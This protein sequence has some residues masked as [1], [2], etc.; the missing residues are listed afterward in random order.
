TAGRTPARRAARERERAAAAAAHERAE[1]HE[2]YVRWEGEIRSHR[3]AAAAAAAESERL[4][5]QL[6]DLDARAAGLRREVEAVQD[7]IR[8]LDAAEGRHADALERAEAAVAAAEVALEAAVARLH[9]L[10]RER[11]S[12]AARA[13]A[14]RAVSTEAP[15]G[16]AA[17]LGSELDGVLGRL[18][19]HVRIRPGGE[20][21]VAAALGPLG[22]AVV[23]RSTLHAG[24]AV[25]HLRGSR[26]GRAVVLPARAGEAPAVADAPAGSR[27]V[28]DL[29]APN[30]PDPDGILAALQR[31]LAGTFVVGDWERAVALHQVH[32]ELTFVTT[33][34]DVAGPAAFAG[35]C[36]PQPSALLTAAAAENAERWVETLDAD[37]QRAA[38]EM[39][40]ARG[41]LTRRRDD[42]AAATRT[43]NESDALITGAAE[44]L[45]RLHRELE[46]N[47]RQR[48]L[49]QA[50]AEELTVA[51]ERHHRAVRELEAEEVPRSSDQEPAAD[52]TPQDALVEEELERAREAELAARIAVER[53][54]EQVV[55]LE[56]AVADLR[57]EAAEVERALAEA[58][59]RRELRRRHILRC[60]EL[61]T[62]AQQAAAVLERSVRDARAEH[63]RLDR[64]RAARE[65]DLAAARA[66]LRERAAELERV[67][68]ERHAADLRRAEIRHQLEQLERRLRAGFGLP[69][70][71]AVAQ[72]PDAANAS[73]D[74]LVAAEQA[75][76]REVEV[77]GRINP[78]AL[79]QFRA[80]EDRHRFL[81]GQVDDLL[82]SRHD[83]DEVIRAVDD[84]IREVFHGAFVDVAREFAT[85][86][87]ELFPGGDGRLLL[88]DPD[89]L[90][91]T[92]IEVEVRPPGKRVKRLSLLSGGE[93]SLTALGLLFAI[94]RARPSPFYV[95]DEVDAALDDVN[96]QRL[97]RL[98]ESFKTTSQLLVVT[99]Q[100]RTMEIAD[101]L[102]GVTMGADAVS[103]VVAERLREP[104]APG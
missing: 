60:G 101:L 55:Q 35:G 30:G 28:G 32:A 45:A 63:D 58:D 40:R 48:D 85:V 93:R 43:I 34:G 88:T 33:D 92:G 18:A 61:A 77:L 100:K 99:H 2:R 10:E 51:V 26:S 1:A 89:D 102:I 90:L 53:L 103:K 5:A 49:I 12:H 15:D 65:A 83:L 66:R 37:I 73:R 94:F 3:Q 70:D 36:D 54:D 71:D 14:L 74:D 13:Q 16:A 76:V 9:E 50:H 87:Q 56:R 57:R 19:D 39:H 67:R 38:G 46:S 31:A 59:R 68:E 4:N 21:A 8:R 44:Q 79:E 78:L 22:E 69:P 97:L 62:I 11:A 6:A 41:D 96:L 84:R 80:L 72:H 98:L 25:A 29:L 91:S 95:L 23:A 24:R 17:L 82:R 42:L 20:G 47:E 64:A 86:I 81:S 75:L 104:V 52:G 27:P 7:R